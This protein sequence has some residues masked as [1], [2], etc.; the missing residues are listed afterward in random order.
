M[1]PASSASPSR[2]LKS[3]SKKSQKIAEQEKRKRYAQQLFDE[4]NL[5]VFKNGLPANTKL[6]WNARLL[7]TAGRAKWHRCVHVLTVYSIN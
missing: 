6:T 2:G 7:S 5:S 1:S 3:T 4:L